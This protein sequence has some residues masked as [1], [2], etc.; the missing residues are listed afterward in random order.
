M[1]NLNDPRQTALFDVFE[2]ILS[3]VAY[4]KLKSGWQHLFRLAILKLMPAAKLAEHFHPDIGRPTKELYSMAGLLFVMEFRNWTHEEA[5]DAYMFNVD[6]QYALNLVPEQ[7]SLCRRTIERYI[8]LFREKKGV[9]RKKVSEE[10]K[11]VR[12]EWHCR[13]QVGAQTGL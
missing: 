5:A 10:K 13:N 8:K 3:P 6:V 7:Q 2:E 4:R 9:K 12:N 11:G 1:R